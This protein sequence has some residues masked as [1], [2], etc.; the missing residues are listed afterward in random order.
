MYMGPRD[1]PV[2]GLFRTRGELGLG[3]KGIR[4]G[5]GAWYSWTPD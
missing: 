5:F 1:F 2:Q 3:S 4:L